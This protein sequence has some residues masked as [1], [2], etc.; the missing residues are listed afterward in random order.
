MTFSYTFVINK[1]MFD[2]NYYNQQARERDFLDKDKGIGYTRRNI[3]E[4]Q[5]RNGKET[6]EKKIEQLPEGDFKNSIQTAYYAKGA[7]VK[8]ITS[9]IKDYQY[10]LKSN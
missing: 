7:G 10:V 4:I 6:M 9:I 8:A 1:K 3:H 5:G 2:L